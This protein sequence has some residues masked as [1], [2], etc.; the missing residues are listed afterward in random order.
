MS[1]SQTPKLDGRSTL[2][3]TRKGNSPSKRER[4]VETMPS[5]FR[6]VE[7]ALTQ[8]VVAPHVQSANLGGVESRKEMIHEPEEGG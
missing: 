3:S 2:T 1:Q 8:G 5:S 4:A 7:L 6:K